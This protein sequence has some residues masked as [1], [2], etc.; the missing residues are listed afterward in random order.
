MFIRNILQERIAYHLRFLYFFVS[1][2]IV[3]LVAFAYLGY[4]MSAN[5]GGT[6]IIFGA[7]WLIYAGVSAFL[8]IHHLKQFRALAQYLQ[9]GSF[10]VIYGTLDGIQVMH[11]K[12]VRYIINKQTFEGTI[13]LH[14]FRSFQNT[15]V[16]K[17]VSSHPRTVELYLAPYGLILGA[18]YPDITSS[19]RQRRPEQEDWDQLAQSLWNGI[20]LITYIGIAFLLIMVAI[21]GFLEYDSGQ[22]WEILLLVLGIIA[23]IFL[24]FILIHLAINRPAV[25][26]WLNKRDPSVQ[27]QIIK[28]QSS[29]WYLTAT[30]YGR[31][32]GAINF[33]GWIRLAG[34]LHPIQA[35]PFREK[36]VLEPLKNPVQV[37]Y[38]EY[39]GR[40][41]FLRSI[42][43]S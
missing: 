40:L 36:D 39:K 42:S 35:D 12:K 7:L 9:Q 21:C 13:A 10:P 43:C 33:E 22:G 6:I 29:E 24:L 3:L 38:M 32:S 23:S 41:I 1:I 37:E 27:V 17:V 15:W 34:I 19:S 31:S 11:K 18:C 2:G 8:F 14:G 26:A 5:D 25:S 16:E 30:K 28:G 20:K 4:S